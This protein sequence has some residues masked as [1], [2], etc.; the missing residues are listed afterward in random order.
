MRNLA[1][2]KPDLLSRARGLL[3]AKRA[4][5]GGAGQGPAGGGN[6]PASARGAGR[7]VPGG[8]LA[9]EGA[10]ARG[11]S[12]GRPGS[13][14]RAAADAARGASEEELERLRSLGYAAS[15]AAPR[16]PGPGRALRDP[17]EMRGF[18]EAYYRAFALLNAGRIEEAIGAYRAMLARDPDAPLVHHQLGRALRKAKQ[19]PEAER[20]FREALR[21]APD[22]AEA[23]L[24]IGAVRRRSPT[25]RGPKRYRRA[26]ALNP[27]FP[28]AH[29]ALARLRR[30]AGDLEGAR[31]ELRAA[32]ALAPSDPCTGRLSRASNRP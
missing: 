10:L 28:E 11:T 25:R 32:L 3:D 15:G 12:A 7:G 19:Y 29:A 20:Q 22:L 14:G 6:G 13:E 1:A 2:E 31:A 27:A 18:E 5:A 8:T 17:K 16:L 24:D 9:T 26:L 23:A 21:L 4:A 30:S